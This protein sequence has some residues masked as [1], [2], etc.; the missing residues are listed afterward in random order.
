MVTPFE[1]FTTNEILGA[2]ADHQID[3]VIIQYDKQIEAAGYYSK[4][5]LI[6]IVSSADGEKLQQLAQ[7]FSESAEAKLEHRYYTNCDLV[8]QMMVHY[9]GLFVCYL[10]ICSL[11]YYLTWTHYQGTQVDKSL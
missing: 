8:G 5:S 9:L 3:G 7:P 1:Y 6:A 2:S 4:P 11:W 10:A